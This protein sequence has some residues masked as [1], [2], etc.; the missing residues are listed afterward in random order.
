M[1]SNKLS[2]TLLSLIILIIGSTLFTFVHNQDREI[3]FEPDDHYS[4]LVNTSNIKHCKISKCYEKNFF[5]NKPQKEKNKINLR[6]AE[7]SASYN[8]FRQIH[9]LVLDYTPL[10]TFILDKSSNLKNMK[11]NF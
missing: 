9:R 11:S 5:R 6:N 7:S 2:I 1:P 3:Y 4:Y 8:Y 10:Y